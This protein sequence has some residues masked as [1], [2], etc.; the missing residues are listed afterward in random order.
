MTE[1]IE[2]GFLRQ[3][4][5]MGELERNHTVRPQDACEA[6][7]KV[8][9]IRHLRQ[10]V[11]RHHQIRSAVL[12]SD[13]HRGFSVEKA[14]LSRNA[15]QLRGVRGVHRGLDSQYGDPGLLEIAQQ[16]AIV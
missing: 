13:F 1:G 10:H 9:Q 2:L 5:D 6:S 15:K 7:G 8:K 12:H 16:I 3:R 4:Q 14:D 11:V